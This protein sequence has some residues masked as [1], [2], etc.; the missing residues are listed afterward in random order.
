MGS[1]SSLGRISTEVRLCFGYSLPQTPLLWE[2]LALGLPFFLL[3]LEIWHDMILLFL[4][5][6]SNLCTS[7]N[8]IILYEIKGF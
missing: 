7:C 4:A 1:K 6:V 3:K 8:L 5:E 2:P